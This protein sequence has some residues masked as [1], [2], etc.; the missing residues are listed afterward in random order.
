MPSKGARREL[1]EESSELDRVRV[2]LPACYESGSGLD[3]LDSIIRYLCRSAYS[4]SGK[5]NFESLEEGPG[6]ASFH[7]SRRR[8][9]PRA[10]CSPGADLVSHSSRY[11]SGYES[12]IFEEVESLIVV[13]CG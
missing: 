7:S 13:E 3:S 12:Q 5:G 11:P 10:S 1:A 6:S 8:W 4:I 9:V 2:I